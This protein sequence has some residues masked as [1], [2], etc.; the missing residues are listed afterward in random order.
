MAEKVKGKVVAQDHPHVSGDKLF[1]FAAAMR[2]KGY[3]CDFG[4]VPAK[5]KCT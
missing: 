5:R 2:R 1:Q 3:R 4:N